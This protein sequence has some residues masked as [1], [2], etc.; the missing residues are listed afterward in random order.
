MRCAA[1]SDHFEIVVDTTIV[2]RF[3]SSSC[4][5]SPSISYG[6]TEAHSQVDTYSTVTMAFLAS[7]FCRSKALYD[8]SRLTS[9][10]TGRCR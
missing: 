6:I 9:K 8:K 3:P 7:I 2:Y 1:R 10:S 4:H 5:W